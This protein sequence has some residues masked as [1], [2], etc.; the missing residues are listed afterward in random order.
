MADEEKEELSQEEMKKTKGGLAV[1]VAGAQKA[2]DSVPF[3]EDASL[4]G[5]A[6]K[7]GTTAPPAAVDDRA[8]ARR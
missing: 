6:G 3:V 5:E 2:E 8:K 7:L 1:G 4:Q